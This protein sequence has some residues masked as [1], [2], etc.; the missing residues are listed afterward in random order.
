M[1]AV[2]S[3]ISLIIFA[4][5]GTAPLTAAT[6]VG[7]RMGYRG[8]ALIAPWVAAVAFGLL[9]GFGI[10]QLNAE[11]VADEEPVGLSRVTSSWIGALMLS[12]YF[13]TLVYLIVLAVRRLP[14]RPADT[15]AVF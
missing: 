15:A 3:L 6:F 4:I 12:G 8:I 2:G 1:S 5:I 9:I 13:S 7:R 14:T 11:V 10:L